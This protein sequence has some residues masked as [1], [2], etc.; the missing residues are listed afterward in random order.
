LLRSIDSQKR[1][2]LL[3]ALMICLHKNNSIQNDFSEHYK[4]YNSKTI[5]TNIIPTI[6]DILK[7]E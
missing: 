6:M 2:I 1:P 3:S 7:K 5:I 4:T